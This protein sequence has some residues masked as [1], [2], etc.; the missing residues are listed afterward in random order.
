MEPISKWQAN[1]LTLTAFSS[2]VGPNYKQNWWNDIIG[3]P[4]EERIEK[5]KIGAVTESGNFDAG[6]LNL[7]LQAGRIDWNYSSND[8]RVTNLSS[9]AGN[10]IGTISDAIFIFLPLMQSW[11]ELLGSISI[12]R[13]A[14]GAIVT[15]K[16][17]DKKESYQK[18]SEYLHDI[19]IDVDNSTDFLYQINRPRKMIVDD[20]EIF[21]NRL[22]KWVAIRAMAAQFSLYDDKLF[23][24]PVEKNN[25]ILVE[26][27]I[28]SS[29]ENQEILENLNFA[30]LL[31]DFSNMA[32]EIL[33]EGDI[34]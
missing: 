34:P 24:Q 21:I 27:D 18:L 6:L 12:N 11:L 23:Q 22:M 30:N 28:N 1:R 19:R 2:I 13:L 29:Q 14:F 33:T 3:E 20:K 31:G 26:L 10:P 17:E 9:P 8:E 16:T 25:F 15:Q 5:Q 4:P 7:Q 32:I